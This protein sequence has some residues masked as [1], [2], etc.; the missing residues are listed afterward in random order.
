L[1]LLVDLRAAL[2]DRVVD[3]MRCGL[4]L[5]TMGELGTLALLLFAQL[6]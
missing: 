4:V 5:Q 2:V 3:G 1:T 6:V